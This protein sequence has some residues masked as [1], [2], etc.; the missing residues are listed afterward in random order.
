MSKP[1]GRLQQIFV[2]FSEKLNF[3]KPYDHCHNISQKPL[4]YCYSEGT[5]V[6]MNDLIFY[7]IHVLTRT[8]CVFAMGWK[9][10][11]IFFELL[12][13]SNFY[14]SFIHI[15]SLNLHGIPWVIWIDFCAQRQQK[16]HF[17]KLAKNN[18]HNSKLFKGGNYSL[19]YGNWF[20]FRKDLNPLWVLRIWSG[21][22]ESFERLA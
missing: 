8:H 20:S 22:A 7:D 5:A 2:V 6:G 14:Q 16:I 4:E 10:L 13:W 18:V 12:L 17:F 21:A 1:W 9:L 19:I 15:F 11:W 3:K